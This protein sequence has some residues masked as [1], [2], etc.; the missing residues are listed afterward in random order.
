M[1][2]SSSGAKGFGP[3]DEGKTREE[4]DATLGTYHFRIGSDSGLVKKV[5]FK[6][7]DQPYAREARMTNAGELD[8]DSLREKYDADVELFG[9]AIFK[10]GMH[11]YIDP[12][13][14]GAGEPDRIMT[15]AHRMGLGGYFLVTNVKSSIE[16]GKFQ[17]DVKCIWTASGTG[18]VPDDRCDEG[19]DCQDGS[20]GNASPPTGTPPSAP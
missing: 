1:Y 8:G 16:S 12:T 7:S 9:N 14:V 10:P 17:T 5:K 11:V 13:T 15:I 6:K 19:N 2:V 20:P 4:R 3:P 18:N